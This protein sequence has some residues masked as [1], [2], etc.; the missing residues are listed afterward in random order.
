MSDNTRHYSSAN[1][2]YNGFY[3]KGHVYTDDGLLA[4]DVKPV[5]G[6]CAIGVKSPFIGIQVDGLEYRPDPY[7]KPVAFWINSETLFLRVHP[8][9]QDFEDPQTEEKIHY[10]RMYHYIMIHQGKIDLSVD[11]LCD[12]RF[13]TLSDVGS[14]VLNHLMN[15]VQTQLLLLSNEPNRC[16]QPLAAFSLNDRFTFLPISSPQS[17]ID[18]R[19]NICLGNVPKNHCG[20]FQYQ[21]FYFEIRREVSC[22]MVFFAEHIEEAPA[23][24]PET[25]LR[26]LRDTF[27]PTH[28]HLLD[29]SVLSYSHQ[30]IG[31]L[32]SEPGQKTIIVY[33]NPPVVKQT[34]LT[35]FFYLHLRRRAKLADDNLWET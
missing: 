13:A 15:S 35:R 28:R 7:G 10:G 9:F 20:Y 3:Y 17:L 25:L 32:L 23:H 33:R 4:L 31:R 1:K 6:V 14:D 26:Q 19:N 21:G 27:T 29:G 12:Y 30:N 34:L 24:V 11:M 2:C 22:G 8:W 5:D 16:T 18:Y